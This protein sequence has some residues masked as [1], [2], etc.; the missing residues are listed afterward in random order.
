MIILKYNEY[1]AV[2]L[3]RSIPSFIELNSQTYLSFKEGEYEV[4]NTLEEGLFR[5]NALYGQNPEG[6]EE[7]N[8]YENI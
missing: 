8:I 3:K 4:F 6:Y 7:V 1:K 2:I 5:Y